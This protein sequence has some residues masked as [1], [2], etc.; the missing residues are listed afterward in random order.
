[1]PTTAAIAEAATAAIARAATAVTA[2]DTAFTAIPASLATVVAAHA[3]T[4]IAS[5]SA[6][7]T[8]ILVDFAAATPLPDS[9][10]HVR[11]PVRRGLL[12]LPDAGARGALATAAGLAAAALALAATTLVR[13]SALA[14][15]AAAALALAAAAATVATGHSLR[16]QQR[17]EPRLVEWWRRPA[18][19]LHKD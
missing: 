5:C 1:M 3:T 10:R 11:R 14:A 6:V 2:K 19:C 13:V 9:F 17:H 7:G 16:L 15:A 8:P 4:C 18:I 12:L